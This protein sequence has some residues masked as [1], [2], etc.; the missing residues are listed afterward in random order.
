FAPAGAGHR[1]A[2][3]E[4]TVVLDPATPA[5]IQ[6]IERGAVP[7]YAHTPE[8]GPRVVDGAGARLAPHVDAGGFAIEERG[9]VKVVVRS[10]GHFSRGASSCGEDLGYVA[11]L[12][13]ER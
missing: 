4:A 12:T 13:F 11:R 6:S 5:V 3:G 10:R 2:R 7:V 1:E 9:P 8:A